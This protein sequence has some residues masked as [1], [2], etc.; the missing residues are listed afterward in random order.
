MINV[1]YPPRMI[2]KVAKMLEKPNKLPY[3]ERKR[4]CQE[5]YG[6]SYQ[7]L[8]RIGGRYKVPSARTLMLLGYELYAKDTVTGELILMEYNQPWDWNPVNP[9]MNPTSSSVSVEE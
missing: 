7:Y 4:W 3:K 9:V 2:E 6:L 8:T 5:N 1:D